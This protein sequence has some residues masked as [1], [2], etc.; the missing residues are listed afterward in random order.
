VDVSE[1]GGIPMALTLRSVERL[2]DIPRARKRIAATRDFDFNAI[3][4]P[5]E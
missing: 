1:T 3:S 2:A 4:S 5:R